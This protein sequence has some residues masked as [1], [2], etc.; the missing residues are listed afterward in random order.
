MDNRRIAYS[1]YGRVFRRLEHLGLMSLIGSNQRCLRY[2]VNE[3][4]FGVDVLT[5]E[6]MRGVIDSIKEQ[7]G[8]HH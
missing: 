2:K 4:V 8:E 6:V 5:G 1:V 7:L 3:I